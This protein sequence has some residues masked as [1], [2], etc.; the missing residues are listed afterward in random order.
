MHTN[1][2]E[3]RDEGIAGNRK[4]R[5]THARAMK[6]GVMGEMLMVES[7]AAAKKVAK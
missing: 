5:F 4:G 1:L 7:V 6:S 3:T 2:R